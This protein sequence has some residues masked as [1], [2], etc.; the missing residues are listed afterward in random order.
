MASVLG[1]ERLSWLAAS[2]AREEVDVATLVAEH[3][4]LL[5]RVAFSVVRRGAEAED[6]V[7]ETFLRAVQ[8]R[9]RLVQVLEVRAW[10]VKV[11]WNLALDRRRR[12]KWMHM[13]EEDLRALPDIAALPTD[14][15]LAAAAELGRVLTA[16][17]RLPKLERSVLLLSAVEE[18]STSEIA[19]VVGRSESGVR[20]LVYRARTH[21][22]QRLRNAE[23]SAVGTEKERRMR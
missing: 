8:Q 17:E 21:L 2:G 14:R 5:Y 7:Q 15:R 13:A 19:E 4:G 1:E 9:G 10:L 18:L 22:E 16:M 23:R 11:A 12:V 20:S 6:V 3:A